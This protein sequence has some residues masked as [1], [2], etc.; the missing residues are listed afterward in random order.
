MKILIADDHAVVRQGLKQ[1]LAD[2]F[3]DACFGEAANGQE[4]VALAA[5]QRWD[6][7][8]LDVSMPGRSGLEVL[9]DLKKA[10]PK[11]PVLMMSI[12]PEEQYA[13]RALKAGASGYLTKESAP[14]VLVAA[15]KKVVAGG[16]YV[17]P[18]LAE[19]VV[20]DLGKEPKQL[21]PETLSDRELEVLKL[22]A[23]GKGVKEIAGELSLSEKTVFTYRER[24]RGKLGLKSDV[25][26]ARYALRQGLVE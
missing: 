17:S 8:V 11:M 10:R 7:A 23:V 24:L 22:N 26:L 20:A 18:A 15:V 3:E 25:E 2:E 21:P 4:A 1:I 12:H 13:V 5:R 6:V 19:K 14:E 16:R 9:K